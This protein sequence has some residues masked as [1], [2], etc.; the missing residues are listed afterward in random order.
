MGNSF[1]E[2]PAANPT[3]TDMAPPENDQFEQSLSPT[4]ENVPDPTLQTQASRNE[5]IAATPAQEAAS[6]VNENLA[7]RKGHESQASE[8]KSKQESNYRQGQSAYNSALADDRKHGIRTHLQ[9]PPSAPTSSSALARHTVVSARPVTRVCSWCRNAASNR[10]IAPMAVANSTQLQAYLNRMHQQGSIRSFDETANGFK[11]ETPKGEEI[12]FDL[13]SQAL[14]I[15]T[16]RPEGF[17]LAT[18]MA[19]EAGAHEVDLS[20]LRGED[21]YEAFKQAMEEGLDVTGVD[22]EE[23]QEMQEQYQQEAQ[24]QERPAHHHR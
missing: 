22:E 20:E 14:E 19:R 5:T 2:K 7:E 21:R 1:D 15:N 23:L 16:H 9:A 12:S 17:E 13:V 10:I 6:K 3:D 4:P 8:I 18:H 11:A 24:E